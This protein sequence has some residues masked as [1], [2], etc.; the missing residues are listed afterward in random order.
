MHMLSLLDLL[1][2][3]S[4]LTGEEGE[5][6]TA[7]ELSKI[8]PAPVILLKPNLQRMGCPSLDRLVAAVTYDKKSLLKTVMKRWKYGR[9]PGMEQALAPLIRA[10][11]P[12][13]DASSEA[14]LCPVPLH[15]S[16]KFWR[17]FNQAEVIAQLISRETE[18]P[19]RSLLR[20]M[21]V[22]GHQAH[23]SGQE[24]RVALRGAF[25]CSRKPQRTI[26]LIDDVCTTG[27]TLEQCALEL[28]KQGADRVEA[29]VLALD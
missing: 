15:W 24:R 5:W 22:T 11:V 21:R 23:R 7:R 19:V 18:L 17:G 8:T 2:P 20:R 1:F 28:K 16:R 14:V 3:K 25:C 29:M 9:M 6:V 10:L 4:S 13:V 26:L 27:S 12:H